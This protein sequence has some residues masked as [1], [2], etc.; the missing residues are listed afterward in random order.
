MPI[1]N[2]SIERTM[3]SFKGINERRVRPADFVRLFADFFDSILYRKPTLQTQELEVDRKYTNNQA[4]WEDAL[5]GEHFEE[6]RVHLENFNLT[7][8]IPSAPGRYFTPEATESRMKAQ[9]Y[10]APD[11]REYLPLG[12]FAMVL[13]GIGSLRMGAKLVD[14]TPTYFLCASS[15]GISH[16]GIPVAMN[17]DQYR[18]AI[19][20][21][22]KHGGCVVNLTGSLRL[23]PTFASII[24]YDREI[25]RYCFFTSDMDLLKPSSEDELLTSIAV[26]FPSC[27]GRVSSLTRGGYTTNLEKMWSFCSFNPSKKDN[28]SS[29]VNWLKGYAARYSN[30]K[31]PPILSNFDEHYRHFENPT[32][33]SLSELFENTIDITRLNAYRE[34]YGLTINI[35][36]MA[37]GDIFKNISNSTI[38]NRSIVEKSFDKVQEKYDKETAM[39]LLRV[40]EEIS[41]SGNKE[42]AELFEEF[43]EELQKP[44]PRQSVMKSVW[45]GIEKALPTIVQLV[46]VVAKISKLFAG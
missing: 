21:I 37:M 11:R 4:F 9:Q 18:D 15:T 13:G 25:P 30:M 29:A 8:W 14:A 38:V 23:L 20:L 26:M 32:E 24:Q 19:K 40:A 7:E 44:K 10:F 35:G 41:K 42:A 46:D 39:A 3:R 33:F 22:K 34:Y 31:N 27:H 12:K 28:L 45:G 1:K 16:Q 5:K 6:M 36:E 17:K 2:T 43:N